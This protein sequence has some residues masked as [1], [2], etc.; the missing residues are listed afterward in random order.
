[1]RTGLK[2]RSLYFWKIARGTHCLGAPRWVKKRS[3]SL[4]VRELGPFSSHPE[5]AQSSE[6]TFQCTSIH[7]ARIE[8][9]LTP[10]RILE[11]CVGAKHLTIGPQ[12]QPED[13][14]TS[15]H[16]FKE[17]LPGHCE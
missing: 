6:L 17:L 7:L 8:V 11:Y 5:C 4:P 15:K 10:K 9:Q 14:E 12:Q 16:E 3:P 2:L 13:P 1:M